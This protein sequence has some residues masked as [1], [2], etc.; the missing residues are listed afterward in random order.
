MLGEI[1]I[2]GSVVSVPIYNKYAG[3][4]VYVDRIPT[5]GEM[6]I[7]AED[8]KYFEFKHDVHDRG[9]MTL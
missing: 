1:S 9:L 2:E 5:D 6:Q 3:K 8:I 4:I 7:L